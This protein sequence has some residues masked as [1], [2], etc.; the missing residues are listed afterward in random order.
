MIEPWPGTLPMTDDSQPTDGLIKIAETYG[1]PSTGGI[2]DTKAVPMT[3]RVSMQA[4]KDYKKQIE[5]EIEHRPEV[6]VGT[7]ATL[8]ALFGRERLSNAAL[9]DHLFAIIDETDLS[10]G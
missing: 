4:I 8:N 9:R 5:A 3:G 7:Q 1:I 6:Y 2:W 10:E